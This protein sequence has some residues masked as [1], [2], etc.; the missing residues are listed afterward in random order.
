MGQWF[1][2]PKVFLPPFSSFLSLSPL[3]GLCLRDLQFKKKKWMLAK[4][5]LR[6]VKEVAHSELV[7]Q[8]I[9]TSTINLLPFP[10]PA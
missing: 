8:P 5:S 9:W 4:M 6:Y 3:L 10:N 2:Q 7:T 1:I